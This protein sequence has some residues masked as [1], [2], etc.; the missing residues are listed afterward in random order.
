MVRRCGLKPSPSLVKSETSQLTI[1]PAG[2]LTPLLLSIAG[3]RAHDVRRDLIANNDGLDYVKDGGVY[4]V[5]YNAVCWNKAQYAPYTAKIQ[6]ASHRVTDETAPVAILDPDDQVFNFPNKITQ[7]D[8]DG[9]VQERGLYYIQ[10]RDPHFKA[11]LS[12]HDPGNPPLDGGLLWPLRQ[13]S[14]CHFL[15]L[16]SS[17]SGRC[18]ARFD[19]ANLISLGVPR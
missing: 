11:L 19:L 5:Q 7:K 8:F 18:T 15:F 17:T 3:I 4:I 6:N 10:E 13:R 1:W 12:C 14:L 16:V 2:T 9:W